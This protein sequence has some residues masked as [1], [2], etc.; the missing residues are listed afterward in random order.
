MG[1]AGNYR[2]FIPNFA[3]LAAPLSDLMLK[4]QPNKVT[5][6]EAQ[7]K[8]YQSIKALLTKGTSPST[9]GSRENLLPAN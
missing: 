7:E 8:A 5:W 2:D 6:G 9:A 3:A 1:F 4:G